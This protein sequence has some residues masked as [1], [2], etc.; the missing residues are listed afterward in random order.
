MQSNLNIIDWT[1]L[2]SDDLPAFPLKN[3]GATQNDYRTA[4]KVTKS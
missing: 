4:I 2:G 3:L 1:N